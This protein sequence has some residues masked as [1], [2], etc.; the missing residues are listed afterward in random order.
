MSIPL[1]EIQRLY[2]PF[3]ELVMTSKPAGDLKTGTAE[4]IAV[5][6]KLMCEVMSDSDG[7]GGRLV[8][9]S[10]VGLLLDKKDG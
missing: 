7:E 10:V 6:V 2:I 9:V 4:S 3:V 8:L 5:L 1:A